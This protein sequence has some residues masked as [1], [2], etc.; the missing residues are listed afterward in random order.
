MVE[1]CPAEFVA[2]AHLLGDVAGEILRARAA[3]PPMVEIKGDGSPVTETDK[4]VEAAVRA[5]ILRAFPAHGIHGE[6]FP[7]S[8]S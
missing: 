6:E 3:L 7:I 5:E 2:F 8:M 4:A 1:T